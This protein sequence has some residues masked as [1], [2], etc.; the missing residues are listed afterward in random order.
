MGERCFHTIKCSV[1]ELVCR[2]VKMSNAYSFGSKPNVR[3]MESHLAFAK[4]VIV[5]LSTWT[6]A[7]I[8]G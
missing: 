5:P 6:T 3:D 1:G 7:A 4:R 2:P 8:S